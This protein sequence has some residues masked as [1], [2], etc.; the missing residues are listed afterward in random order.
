MVEQKSKQIAIV[1]RPE[2]MSSSI[3]NPAP[4]IFVHGRNDEST[5]FFYA[6]FS[7]YGQPLTTF[8]VRLLTEFQV[9][10][11][12]RNKFTLSIN[13]PLN[14]RLGNKDIIIFFRGHKSTSKKIRTHEVRTLG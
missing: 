14:E 13:V 7:I 10:C 5:I 2:L 1:D 8:H 11:K 3:I 6:S 12:N 4:A 9:S